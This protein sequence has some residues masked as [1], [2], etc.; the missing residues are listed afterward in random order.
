MAF[1]Y[2]V[3]VDIAVSDDPEYQQ[4]VGYS[5]GGRANA[6]NGATNVIT[7]LDFNTETS[8]T[9]AL[10]I[11]N[12]RYSSTGMSSSTKGLICGGYAADALF[13]VNDID[14]IDF[15]TETMIQ[16]TLTVGSAIA[17]AG[18]LNG[19]ASG[20]MWS[21]SYGTNG[22]TSVTGSTNATGVSFSTYSY[23]VY[24]A[25]AAL[26]RESM[27]TTSAPLVGYGFGGVS[28]STTYTEIDGLALDS[29]TSNNP[30]A[31]LGSARQGATGLDNTVTGF[32]ASGSN[33]WT[34]SGGQ[35]SVLGYNMLASTTFDVASTFS[36]ATNK[37]HGVNG[38]FNGYMMGGIDTSG[39]YLS[40]IKK[41]GFLTHI[42]G[43]VSSSLSIVQANGTGVWTRNYHNM[44]GRSYL[45]GG[46]IGTSSYVTV[47]QCIDYATLGSTRFAGSNLSLARTALRGIS[48]ARIGYFLGG[49]NGTAQTLIDGIHYSTEVQKTTSMTLS[50]ARYAMSTFQSY[51]R[52]YSCGGWQGGSVT[53]LIEGFVFDT[54]SRV[55]VSNAI[56]SPLYYG[57]GFSAPNSTYGWMMG[58]STVGGSTS[59]II[60]GTHL[61]SETSITAT[62]TF[63]TSRYS[64]T[65]VGSTSYS[66]AFYCG[67]WTSSAVTTV[68]GFTHLSTSTS[69]LTTG[70]YGSVLA[71]ARY[72]AAGSSSLTNGYISGGYNGTTRFSS[73]EAI[74]FSSSAMSATSLSL[75]FTTTDLASVGAATLFN[76]YNL[77]G[78]L[79]GGYKD[80]TNVMQSGIEVYDFSSEAC[81]LSSTSISPASRC[82]GAVSSVT[83]GYFAGGDLVAST[84]TTNKIFKFSYSSKAY[85]DTA[86]VLADGARANLDGVNS[87]SKGYWAGGRNATTT[88]TYTKCDGWTFAT[89]AY[90]TTAAA[91]SAGRYAVAAF[92]SSSAG[93]WN[94]G[95][96]TT[97]TYFNRTDK[98][99]FGTDTT[100]TSLG[101]I[102]PTSRANAGATNSSTK[103]YYYG[104]TTSASTT[105]AIYEFTFSTD[106]WNGT[107]IAAMSQAR[108]AGR[109]FGTE[110]SGYIAGGSNFGNTV[111]YKMIDKLLYST[112][113]CLVRD[114]VLSV[115]KSRA[116][117]LSA[118]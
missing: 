74:N 64:A 87:A 57:T 52:G 24:S 65:A 34:S 56:P 43:N 27:A 108:Q 109:G 67:G 71:T 118:I 81:Y 38:S 77:S 59:S 112:N 33:I 51:A 80:D 115:P 23:S 94:G 66:I 76:N 22:G 111:S 104:G 75:S 83:T 78:Y 32:I 18:G 53:G 105:S 113:T 28:G 73:T 85:S 110:I 2:K 50:T 63:A 91:L 69:S 20:F 16:T 72:D 90:Y 30:S 37:A 54:E 102:V 107:S 7:S 117:A 25:R 46:S 44:T 99:L 114:A 96:N 98:M 60:S 101:N 68:N 116:A 10:Y 5:V 17:G 8:F 106:T 47:I 89:E 41:I 3:N 61:G 36:S 21:G 49:T 1:F 29:A 26:A 15:S 84:T 55:A 12:A 35:T 93:Y 39:L 97:P 88:T 48:S 6:S 31:V 82:Q 58:G 40:S 100:I 62:A 86:Q 13:Y 4:G 95:L 79:F 45:G 11:T 14:V 103:G 92:N 70:T 19:P 42:T 9:P